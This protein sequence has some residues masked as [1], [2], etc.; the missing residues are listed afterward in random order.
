MLRHSHRLRI[1]LICLGMAVPAA[2]GRASEP[3]E[4]VD[5][6]PSTAETESQPAVRHDWTGAVIPTSAQ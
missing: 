2:T 4:D 3:N 1:V 5:R 6:S